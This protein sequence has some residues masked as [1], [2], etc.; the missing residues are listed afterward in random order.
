MTTNKHGEPWDNFFCEAC[1]N[2]FMGT[3]VR[4]EDGTRLPVCDLCWNQIPVGQKIKLASDWKH[5]RAIRK[6]I[7]DS[8]RWLNVFEGVLKMLDR[9]QQREA[10][11]QD[12]GT[13]AGQWDDLDG[14]GIGDPWAEETE[15]DGM[16]MF[17]VN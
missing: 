16:G 8:A 14:E 6:A 2:Q 1:Q 12:D 15:G 11:G 13:E 10:D 9:N 5:Q 7:D 4:L 3:Q 17:G